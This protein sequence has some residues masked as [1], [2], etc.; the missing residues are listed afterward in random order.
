MLGVGLGSSSFVGLPVVPNNRRHGEL[1]EW[2]LSPVRS[3]CG[4]NSR[5]GS[6]PS[7]TAWRLRLMIPTF[8]P[9]PELAAY[10]AGYSYRYRD[11]FG[12]Q[13]GAALVYQF[14]RRSRLYG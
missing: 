9:C 3:G 2:R 8:R 10:V 1:T 6:S 14:I 4:C 13:S 11:V 7:L 12:C 5:E